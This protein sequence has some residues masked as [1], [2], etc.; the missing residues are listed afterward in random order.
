MRG[1]LDRIDPADRDRFVQILAF[2]R[3]YWRKIGLVFLLTMTSTLFALAYPLFMKFLI[4]RIFTGHDTRL[5][6]IVVGAM[7]LVAVL[8]FVASATGGY[9]NTWVTARV[10][11]DMRLSRFRHLP[12]VPLTFFTRE[13]VGD[14]V[15]RINGDIS[16]V[17][18]IA[19]GALLT[20][21]G[22]LLT[23]VGT[24]AILL[25]LNWR[26]FLLSGVLIPLTW[27]ILR[28]FRPKI[29]RLAREIRDIN[30]DIASFVIEAFSGAKFIRSHGLEGFAARRFLH[31]NRELILKV[32]RF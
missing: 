29:R 4:D 16:E 3:P 2:V 27:L 10:L 30:S 21:A 20:L 12:R 14:M 24:A 11:L 18:S 1:I 6:G 28:H 8:R 13:R 26:L 9:V 15:A 5:L 31:K 17:Q 25:W 19:T 32:L 7:F 23:L 22:S